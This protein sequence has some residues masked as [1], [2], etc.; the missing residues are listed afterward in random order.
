MQVARVFSFSV[1]LLVNMKTKV[2]R[3]IINIGLAECESV[4]DLES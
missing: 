2:S 1:Q 4:D 3:I